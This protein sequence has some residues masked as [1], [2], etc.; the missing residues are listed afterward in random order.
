MYHGQATWR[1]PPNLTLPA[2]SA[3]LALEHRRQGLLEGI[4]LGLELWFG[5]D[6]IRWLAEI[7]KIQD[8]DVLKALQAGLEAVTT[9][10]ELY[11]PA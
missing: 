5:A 6:G 3:F 9:L 7:L 2:K 1:V 10:D 8:T 11:Q 4:E